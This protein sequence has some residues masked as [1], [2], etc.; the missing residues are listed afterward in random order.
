MRNVKLFESFISESVDFGKK[1]IKQKLEDK[2]SKA[3]MAVSKWGDSYNSMLKTVETALK[4]GKLPDYKEPFLVQGGEVE[5]EYDIFKGRNAVRLAYQI[6]KVIEKYKKY[7]TEQSSIPAAGGWSGTMRSTVGGTI[8]G[9]ANF[10]PD[11]RRRYLIAVTCGGGIDSKIKDKMFQEIYSLLFVLDQYNSSD[12]GVF[13]N[14]QSGTNYS[15]LGL[16]SGNGYGFNK[17]FG[18]SLVDIINK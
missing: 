17:S 18:Q 9:R 5:D 14:Y 1:G 2:L 16:V 3:K 11:G 7:E 8:E 12:G 4:T 15:T 13:V 10:S 6:N